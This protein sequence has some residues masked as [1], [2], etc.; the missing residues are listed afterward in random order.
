MLTGKGQCT[1]IAKWSK[2]ITFK[3]NVGHGIYV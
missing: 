2:F 1:V 3:Q